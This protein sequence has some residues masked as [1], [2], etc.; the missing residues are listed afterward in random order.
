MTLTR[1]TQLGPYEVGTL[2]GAGAM[3][4]VYRGRDPRLGRD[5]AIKVLP[6]QFLTDPERLARFERESR[7]V[8]TLN[9]P[10]IVAIYDT[11]T[12]VGIRFIVCELLAGGT[13]REVLTPGVPLVF[14][15]VIEISHQI[16][17]GLAAA[18]VRGVV[19]R[20]LKPRTSSSAT[21]AW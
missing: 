17:R 10:N 11:G 15:K 12:A 13:L 20:D 18:H 9:H 8:A 3:G 5:V 6:A 4:E 1:G 19:H 21:T 16:A 7:I 2:L 14:R